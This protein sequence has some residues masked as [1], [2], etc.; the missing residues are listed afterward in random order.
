[1]NEWIMTSEIIGEILTLQIKA[2]LPETMSANYFTVTHR[3]LVE[4]AK[5]NVG[6]QLISELLLH[7]GLLF[8][9]LE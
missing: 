3:Y 7:G 5:F 1:M 2:L 6:I 8:L 9:G 4:I